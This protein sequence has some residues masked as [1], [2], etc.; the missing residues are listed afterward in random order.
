MSLFGLI[1]SGRLP[2]SDFVAVDATKLLVNVPDIESV[3]YLV[4]FLTG[5]SPLPVGT[6]AAIYFSWPDANAAPTWQ[7]LGHI[8]NTKPSAIFKIAQLKKSHELEAQAHGMVFG[9]QEISHIAQIGVSLEPELTVAQQTP[10]VSTAND[11]K[12]FGQRMLENFFNYASSFGV[13]ARDIPPISSET[14]VPFSVVQ[15]WYTNF[16]RRMEQNP[17]FWKY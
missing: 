16:Q 7:Y 2:Q 9:S 17:N 1:V 14:F 15:N 5:V 11:N 13:A 3:N 4:V 8:N 10:A 6:S 12:Q